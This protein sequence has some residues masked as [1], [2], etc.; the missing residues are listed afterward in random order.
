MSLILANTYIH[1]HYY[2]SLTDLTNVINTDRHERV[3]NGQM[4]KIFVVPRGST[5]ISCKISVYYLI[6]VVKNLTRTNDLGQRILQSEQRHQNAKLY[7]VLT[8][9]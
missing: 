4:G 9:N 3:T 6:V 8:K 7:F 5:R 1:W 2:I